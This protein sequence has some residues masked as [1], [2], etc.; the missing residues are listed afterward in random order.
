MQNERTYWKKWYITVLLF[1][2]AQILFYY[3]V[4]KYF[5]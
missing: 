5:N 2:I 3:F 4:T 1:L